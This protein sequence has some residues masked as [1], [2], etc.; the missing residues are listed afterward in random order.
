MKILNKIVIVVFIIILIIVVKSNYKSLSGRVIPFIQNGVNNSASLYSD[1]VGDAITKVLADS[2]IKSN[3]NIA[4]PGALLVPEAYLTNNIKSIS[5][6]SKRVITITNEQR[7]LNGNLPPLIENSKLDFSAEKKLQDMFAKQYFEHIS[8]SGVGVGDLGIQSGYEYIVIG[9]NLALGN[10]KDDKSLV[11][12]WMASPGHRAN[13]LNNRYRDIGVAV[14][15]GIYNGKSVW[16]GVQHFGLS[17]SVCP[18]IDEL[19]HGMININQEK[20]K[21]ME[22]TLASKRAK[23]DSGV[24]SDGMT[25]SEQID[26]YNALVVDYN[27]LISDIKAKVV[28]YNE[29]VKSFNSCI[30]EV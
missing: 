19:L 26:S 11:D 9:E 10:F 27:K 24:I 7:A 5:L 15:Q 16:I 21:E 18:T 4:V 17:K 8:P 6:S 12:A 2:K 1:K 13:I 28:K 14:G 25:T 20:A 29:E 22:V 3:T 30:A 23:V